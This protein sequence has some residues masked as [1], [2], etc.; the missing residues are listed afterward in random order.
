MTKRLSVVI[1]IVMFYI[2]FMG[3]FVLKAPVPPQQTQH[4]RNLGAGFD[5]FMMFVQVILYLGAIA[6]IVAGITLFFYSFLWIPILMIVGAF[7]TFCLAVTVG[8]KFKKPCVRGFDSDRRSRLLSKIEPEGS[9]PSALDIEQKPKLTADE[10]KALLNRMKKYTEKLDKRFNLEKEI[11][12]STQ[13]SFTDS[14]VKWL[15]K[16]GAIKMYNVIPPKSKN[17]MD[18]WSRS[19]YDREIDDIN[20]M[21]VEIKKL[22][23]IFKDTPDEMFERVRKERRRGLKLK[24]QRACDRIQLNIYRDQKYRSSVPYKQKLFEKELKPLIEQQNKKGLTKERAEEINK[25]IEEIIAKDDPENPQ[26]KLDAERKIETAR[27]FRRAGIYSEHLQMKFFPSYLRA[28]LVTLMK[29]EKIELNQRM[30]DTP[31]SGKGLEEFKKGV[32]KI[33]EQIDHLVRGLDLD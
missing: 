10:K 24:I 20:A 33:D 16:K 5:I 12:K 17:E 30:R 22:K 1:Q 14:F 9:A 2:N 6:L 13:P 21:N 23:T 32:Q 19:M 26:E 8:D 18:K 31:L 3:P 11:E 25:Q 15:K 7:F 4:R 28:V 29:F 27:L